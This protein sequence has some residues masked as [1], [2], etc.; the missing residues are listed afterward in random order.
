M[1]HLPNSLQWRHYNSAVP[2]MWQVCSVSTEPASSGELVSSS[3]FALF[4]LTYLAL[5]E[6]FSSVC[7]WFHASC[8][9]LHSEENVEKAAESSF[10]CT[11][12]RTFKSTKGW[13]T[14][15]R[16][17]VFL[18]YLGVF[19]RLFLSSVAHSDLTTFNPIVSDDCI[20]W[21]LYILCR[22]SCDQ[23]QRRHWA[24]SYDTNCHKS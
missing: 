13:N 18:F 21:L 4:F 16:L 10:D 2:P 14:V 22:C 6:T 19:F 8:Q 1:S 12:C 20:Q 24:C 9:G 7:R 5:N 17:S 23:G 3:I 11:M 15:L